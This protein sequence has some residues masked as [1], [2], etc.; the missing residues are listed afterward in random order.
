MSTRS[1]VGARW[2][3]T[4][5][6]GDSGLRMGVFGPVWARR[7]GVPLDLGGR[8]QRAVLAMLVAARGDVVS[9]QRLVEALW[10]DSP[11]A[12]ALET[13]HAYV[14]RL[15]RALEPDR[16]ARSRG[17]LIA[18]RAPG[19]VLLADPES[20]DAWCFA[21]AV[22]LWA[23]RAAACPGPARDAL[24]AALDLWRG[25]AYADCPDHPWAAADSAR[26]AELRLL[27]RE[28][29]A[30]ARLA[31]GESA[32]LV[33]EL[34][35]MADA[36]PLREERW[37][38]LVLALYRA[39]RQG[40]ALAAL[41]RC[42]AVLADEL[43]VE[44]GPVLRAVEAAVLAHSPDLDWRPVDAPA[45][46]PSPAPDLPPVSADTGPA[47]RIPSVPEPWLVGR[48]TA[49]AALVD[50]A[51]GGGEASAGGPR[52]VPPAAMSPAVRIG[53]ATGEAGCGKTVL[54]EA[55]SA[56][57]A[58]GGCRVAWGRCPEVEGAPALGPWPALLRSLG[59]DAATPGLSAL[60]G[61]EA[62]EADAA[63]DAADPLAR[64]YR[65]HQAA[66]A[67]LGAEARRQPLL[68]IV[69][70]AHHAD[71]DTLDMLAHVLGALADVPVCL[72][73]TYRATA[74]GDAFRAVLAALADRRPL[75]IDLGP[76][77]DADIAVLVRRAAD[78]P[79]DA[80]VVAAA[81][82]RCDGN[83]FYAQEL[84]RVLAAEGSLDD[85]PQGIR[86]VVAHR[87]ARL[88]SGAPVVLRLA[89]IAG[90]DIDVDLL[91]ELSG[92]P[93]DDVLDALDAAHVAGLV[94][95]DGDRLR[96]HHVLVQ[97]ALYRQT[98]PVRRSR[99]HAQVAE[100]LERLRSDDSPALARH[101]AAAG[102][103]FAGRARAHAVRA[104]EQAESRSAFAEAAA[105]WRQAV[106]ATT[107]PAGQLPLLV[108]LCRAEGVRGNAQ[109]AMQA[110]DRALELARPLGDRD[111][112]TRAVTA[113]SVPT[114]WMHRRYM[115]HDPVLIAEI[116]GLL[117]DV[118]DSSD[119]CRL[120]CALVDELE[121]AGDPAVSEAASAAEA[122][123]AA[124]GDP[125]LI[126]LAGAARLR[127]T[128]SE[129]V[130]ER[131]AVAERLLE[132]GRRHG[133]PQMFVL[134]HYSA[135]QAAAA[136]G[137]I[138]EFDRHLGQVEATARTYRLGSAAQPL[139]AARALRC[140]LTGRA[141]DAEHEYDEL[142][143]LMDAQGGHGGFGLAI[144]GRLAI[145]ET[146]GGVAELLPPLRAMH[147]QAP[148]TQR[149]P[150]AM[151]LVAA[152]DLT[153]AR[154]FWLPDAPVPR[155]FFAHMCHALRTRIA[156][157]LDLPEAA[158]AAY[159]ALEP[160]RADL[161]GAVSGSI[162]LAPVAQYLGDVAAYLGD[163]GTAAAHYAEALTL[164]RTARAPHFESRAA[165]ALAALPDGP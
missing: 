62:P 100:A 72:L 113:W 148:L 114:P 80:A 144:I 36:E 64:R 1:G 68:L 41:R 150:L 154:R 142:A 38:L 95:A 165:A 162:T 90:R 159:A 43:G 75:R 17:G 116:R 54:A 101:Y 91:T 52:T 73:L 106:A 77:P 155:D 136:R 21:D 127:V 23:G 58:A 63:A 123:A 16:P 152:G 161:A 111:L 98:S 65:L 2:G 145:R 107:D 129:P 33:P 53:L 93:E 18:S 160:H 128:Y 125:D 27:A 22:A 109:G 10:G 70:D 105:L 47:P 29:V 115:D 24:T 19:Y 4:V 130:A 137:R 25:D 108:A 56:R 51:L 30:E 59:A 131:R 102:P 126:G 7:D 42:R 151:A 104:A 13:L 48:D 26:L 147:A 110:R 8:R 112:L 3:C 158:K 86:D 156:I 122:L 103:A 92:L 83:P 89:A 132:A 149:E 61:P 28:A 121:P 87:V 146:A 82:A 94:E 45:V 153:E 40:D 71:E 133:R 135:Y 44:P 157:A 66:A 46:S 143:R 138:D 55:V 97:E 31:E 5:A 74:A 32:L 85:V 20:V 9:A 96:F 118:R 99:R 34:A 6:V 67:F 84:G 69:D 12:R 14:S 49:F 76:L 81:A 163:P 11:P 119:R 15:R 37:R 164:A 134:G 120:L 78:R 117:A 124:S 88:P 57:A 39:G 60:L 79:L 140:S 50:L 139:Q 141:A 35:D